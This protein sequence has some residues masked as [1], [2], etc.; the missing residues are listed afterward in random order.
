MF[1]GMPA[2][3]CRN[4]QVIWFTAQRKIV[5]LLLYPSHTHTSP[6]SAHHPPTHLTPPPY[7]S[8]STRTLLT[9]PHTQI[10]DMVLVYYRREDN[11]LKHLDGEA[12]IEELIADFNLI[13]DK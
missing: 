11:D 2:T 10:E 4:Y 8:H 13:T 1:N 3:D 12:S 5:S 7:I 9:V 6:H